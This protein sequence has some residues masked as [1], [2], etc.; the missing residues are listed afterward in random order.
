MNRL[1]NVTAAGLVVGVL[2]STIILTPLGKELEENFGLHL[3]FN[4]RGDRRVPPDVIII[5]L[6]K[7]S[8]D[9]LNLPTAPRKWPRSSDPPRRSCVPRTDGR[10]A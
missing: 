6:D 3:L 7:A 5:T 1:L 9:F 2:G 4:A 8:A 10:T